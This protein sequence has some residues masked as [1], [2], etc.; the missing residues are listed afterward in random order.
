[1]LLG[2]GAVVALIALIGSQ[3]DAG[4]KLIQEGEDLVGDGLLGKA[5]DFAKA[6]AFRAAL[7]VGV[8]SYASELIQAGQR[9]GVD[10]WVLAGLMFRE[11]LGG[12]AL[13]PKGPAGTGDFIPRKSGAYVKYADP[14]TGLP[15]D[16]Q[17]WG[18]GLMQIDYGVWNAW[19]TSNDWTDPQ[20]NINKAAEIFKGSLDYF[21]RAAGPDV[22]ID[23][24]RINTGMPQYRI[25]PW[26]V[27]Y[28]VV[29]VASAADPRPLSG[30]ALYEAALAAFNAGPSG[31]LQAVALGLPGEAVTTGQDYTSWLINKVSSWAA[32]F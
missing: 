18:R 16:G 17:G 3:T 8:A 23:Q 10:P 31:V 28:G 14:A 13:K 9:Y 22:K 7:P 12:L 24:W 25:A 5:F 19:V 29:A 20:T 4:Q 11:S 32:G 26:S 27:K 2:A 30:A 15:P 21:T 6:S 1:M